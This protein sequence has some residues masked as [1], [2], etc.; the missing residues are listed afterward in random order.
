MS[1]SRFVSC[2]GEEGV[3]RGVF[4]TTSASDHDA[5]RLCFP[6]VLKKQVRWGSCL[7]VCT[8][9]GR[10]VPEGAQVRR[11]RER[12]RGRRRA[13]GAQAQGARASELRRVQAAHGHRRARGGA[14]GP[15][16]TATIATVGVSLHTLCCFSSNRTIQSGSPR[17]GVDLRDNDVRRLSASCIVRIALSL[18]HQSVRSVAKVPHAECSHSSRPT[19]G[20][21]VH[22]CRGGGG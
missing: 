11:V 18:G 17:K 10:E 2:S 16:H 20:G 14:L 8:G 9:G 22:A 21:P 5:A 4:P 19:A 7:P 1:E 6:R 13:A 3:N 15:P 12:L